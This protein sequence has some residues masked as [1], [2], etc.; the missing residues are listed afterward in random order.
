MNAEFFEALTLLEKERGISADYL[1]EKIQNAIIIAVKRD[2]GESDNIHVDI[3]PEKQTFKVYL[4]KEVV[5][6]VEDPQTQM[7]LEEALT[8]RS[9]AKVGSEIEI[10]LKTKEFGRIAAQTAKHV[11][12]Q[13]IRE[14]ERSQLCE[15]L[16]SKKGEIV[17]ATV[18]RYDQKRGAAVLEIGNSEALLPKAEQVPTETLEDGDRVKVYVVDV[19]VT[20]RGPK[21]MISRTHSG[22][23]KRLFETEVPEIFDGT[24]LIKGISREAGMR[25]K[26]AVWAADENVDPR[27]ACIGPRGSRVARIVDELGG[28]KIDIVLWNEE[29]E[30]YIAEALSPANVVSVEI[31]DP[32][33]RTCRV[34][35][36]D[37]QLS[38]AI[39]NKGQNARLAARLTG[40]KIDI[41]P[42]SGY[43]GEDEEEKPAAAEQAE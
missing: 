20:D 31:L 11:I 25:T 33:T 40:Y 42:E 12:R 24:V 26:I 23:V 16:Q 2:Y 5:E 22:L 39:G 21:I 30:K 7:S 34:T 4:T 3:D 8:Y 17:T 41:R 36:P 35:V 27:G 37:H 13:G 19:A 15:E 38:L 32:E 6:E 1:L 43:Y 9:R 14:A 18:L 28:E 10:P 29:P